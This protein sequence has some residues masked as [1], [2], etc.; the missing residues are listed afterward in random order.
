MNTELLNKVEK[1]YIVNR[2]NVKIGDTVVLDTVIRDGNKKRIQKFK[3]IVIAMQG[4][5]L[6][7][8][9]TVRKVS[10]GIG[11]EKIFPLY[12]PNVE[13]VEILRHGKVRRSKLYYM[14]DR[15][16][17]KATDLKAGRPLEEGI[18]DVSEPE[19]VEVKEEASENKE[20]VKAEEKK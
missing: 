5:G 2:P 7:R 13:K 6:T 14:R 20:E 9:I 19:V 15:V 18:N 12:S 8:T 11:V 17:K 1:N 16:G 3:G 10:Y 4:K